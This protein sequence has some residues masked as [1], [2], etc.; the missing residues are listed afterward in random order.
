M[1][2]LGRRATGWQIQNSIQRLRMT[3][4]FL[5]EI[6]YLEIFQGYQTVSTERTPLV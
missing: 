6:P 1:D 4:A 5:T 2:Q 3:T